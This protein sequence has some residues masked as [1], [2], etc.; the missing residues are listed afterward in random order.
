LTPLIL[1]LAVLLDASTTTIG[2]AMG[3]GEAGPLASRLL[4]VLGLGYWLLELT[5]L[6]FIYYLI[7]RI[8]RLPAEYAILASTAGPW[9]AGWHNMGLVLRVVLGG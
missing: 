4:S 9:T 6:L 2:L 8:A 1:F 3:L 7:R 5:V